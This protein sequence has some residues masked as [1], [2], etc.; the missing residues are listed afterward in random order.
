MD[1]DR[2][3]GP[4]P[5]AL[6]FAVLMG[7]ANVNER[8]VI[9][10]VVHGSAAYR[11]TVELR[12]SMLR[13]PLGLH[14]SAEELAAEKESHHLA[15]YCGARLVGCLVLRP[16]GDSAAQMRQVAVV[17]DLQGQGIGTALVRQCEEL[18]DKMGYRSIILH[19]RDTAVAFYERLGYEK[20]GDRFLEVTIP[21]WAME[22]RPGDSE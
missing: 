21:H 13:A 1:F 2:K 6:D 9:R 14:F 15:C 7:R 20:A 8:L 19:A 11:A 18:A 5:F 22:K 10:E 4:D 12:L 16:L 17:A 3:H